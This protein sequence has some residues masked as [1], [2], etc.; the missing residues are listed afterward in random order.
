M[1]QSPPVITELTHFHRLHQ[2]SLELAPEVFHDFFAHDF[3]WEDPDS[4]GRN[5]RKNTVARDARMERNL[6]SQKSNLLTKNARSGTKEFKS[7]I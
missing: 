6:A 1:S 7:G 5:S 2:Q 3:W 4:V